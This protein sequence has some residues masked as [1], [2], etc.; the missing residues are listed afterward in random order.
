MGVFFFNVGRF[1]IAQNLELVSETMELCFNNDTS[2]PYVHDLLNNFYLPWDTGP[3]LFYNPPKYLNA[4]GIICS[5]SLHSVQ[6]HWFELYNHYWPWN[7]QGEEVEYHITE[8][9]RKSR[10]APRSKSESKKK[11][12]LHKLERTH[13]KRG[14]GLERIG[15]DPKR[16]EIFWGVVE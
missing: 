4:L 12:K 11:P 1:R 7:P 9:K 13:E 6:L 5:G 8:R 3:K 2:T 15:Y 10:N 14:A 16:V